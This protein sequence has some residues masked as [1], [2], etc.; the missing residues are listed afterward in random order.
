[1]EF[2]GIVYS[3]LN[4][5]KDALMNQH[6]KAPLVLII[7]LTLLLAASCPAYALRYLLTPAITLQGTY[8]D[9][10]FFVDDD[11]FEYYIGP[12]ITLDTQ[13][14][15]GNLALSAGW[16]IYEYSSYNEFD[17]I[18]HSYSLSGSYGMT[19]KLKFDLGAA[20]NRDKTFDVELEELALLID[21]E[22]RN[23]YSVRPGLVY[24]INPK[25]DVRLAYLF[26]EVD[27]GG[28]S[29]DNTRH[30][31]TVGW[32][33]H[34]TER[35][36]VDLTGIGSTHKYDSA[37]GG[38]IT[39][40]EASLYGGISYQL[41]ERDTARFYAGVGRVR[42]EN[43][44]TD[45]TDRVTRFLAS[46]EMLR[47]YERWTL[48]GSYL[49][50]IAPEPDGDS[51]TRD[52]LRARVRY[53]FTERLSGTL[54]AYYVHTETNDFLTGERSIDLYRITP[55]LDYRLWENALVGLGYTFS[56][57]DRENRDTEDRNRVYLSFSYELPIEY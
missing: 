2:S 23:T 28:D 26:R 52:R 50:D 8:D 48:S 5:N 46:V 10:V 31:L 22:R 3:G 27:Y 35:T 18:N 51:V 9:N 24:S 55:T 16:H 14:E 36:T 39:Y 21:P 4:R 13:S 49:R 45:E 19:E 40:E 56:R 33:H 42:Y 12:T 32:G 44:E 7:V 15:K 17:R 30:E 41:T 54:I 57:L 1:V 38:D 53:L 43:D 47:R 25:N 29:R 6:R 34:L 11:D 20:F 37:N